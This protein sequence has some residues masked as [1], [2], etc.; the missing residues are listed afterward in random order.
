MKKI[1][2]LG[3][4]ILFALSCFLPLVAGFS[5]E[6]E[7][8]FLLFSGCQVSGDIIIVDD[9]GDGDY[10]SIKDALNHADP[11]DTIEVYSGTYYEYDINI[12]IEDI[13]LKGIPYELENGSD[14]GKPFINGGGKNYVL[15]FRANNITLYNFRIENKGGSEVNGIINLVL[16]AD[17]C[18]ISYNDI[19]HSTMACIWIK[20]SYNKIINNYISH[21]SMRQ[22]IILR[23]PCSNCL[24]SG[25]VI[26]DVEI[27]IDLWDSNHNTITGNKISRC[28]EFGI[29][30]AS[31]DYN[32]VKGNSFEDN[33]VG[34]HIIYNSR[35]SRI[36]N[37]NFI[38]NQLQAYCV[39]GFPFF[40]DLT[41]RW[42]GNYWNESHSLPYPIR[43]ARIFILFVQFDWR[44]AKEPYEI[45]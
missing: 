25:N 39:Y 10:T 33:T 8:S 45:L 31:S 30:I 23:D 4:L 29:D 6:S 16:G 35:G 13:T 27:G 7:E 15:Y 21:S 43:G 26:S 1:I 5:S 36:K 40:Y 17:G 3:V 20:S 41:N 44:P 22:G 11:G 37:N 24:V 18:T 19:A 38:N 12:E 9:E 34:V 2:T 14:I 28:S 32:T 42:N